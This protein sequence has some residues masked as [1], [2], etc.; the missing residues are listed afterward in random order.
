MPRLTFIY[1]RTATNWPQ[2]GVLRAQRT[3]IP[4][5]INVDKAPS[6]PAAVDSAKSAGYLPEETKLRQVKYLNNKIEGDHTPM[7]R[8][9]S[10]GRGFG[11]FDTARKTIRGYEIMRMIKKGQVP[12]AGPTAAEQAKF[13]ESLFG[14]AS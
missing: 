11:S 2:Q 4:R 3:I 12:A 10:P 13:I 9:I 14:M 8:L 6:Y 7:K 1:R 5:V